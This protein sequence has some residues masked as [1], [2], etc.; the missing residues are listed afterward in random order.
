MIAGLQEREELLKPRCPA[1]ARAEQCAEHHVAAVH[2]ER[3]HGIIERA[4]KKRPA[5]TAPKVPPAQ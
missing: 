2:L 3:K 1:V 5:M 4:V